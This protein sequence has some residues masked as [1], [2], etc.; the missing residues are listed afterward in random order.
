MNMREIKSVVIIYNPNSTGDGQKNAE[1]F[2]HKLRDAGISAKTV[3][4]K[5]RGHAMQLAREYAERPTPTMVV[6]SSGD[7]GYNEVI[8]GVLKS[9]RPDTVT[10]VLPSGN[11]NDHYH[12][13]HHGNTVRRI[14]RNDVE[15]IDVLELTMGRTVRYAHSYIGLGMSS[16]I[17]AALT[18]ANLNVFREAWL[19]LTHLFRVRPVKIKVDGRVRRYDHL[20]CFNTG[21]MSKYLTIRNQHRPH[22][23]EFDVVHVK[24]GSIGGLIRHLLVGVSRGTESDLETDEYSFTCLRDT[25]I[26]LDGEVV[27]CDAGTH[28]T[29]RSLRRK[30]STIV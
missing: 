29:I 17:G 9:A 4:T 14:A 10:G 6:S 12:F 18:K 3:P 5:R 20:V 22:D 30:L 19:V 2:A 7:G 28:V 16:Q 13:V 11:A 26:Q 1:K 27:K 24:S 21:R 15:Q 25:D 8:N 23:G